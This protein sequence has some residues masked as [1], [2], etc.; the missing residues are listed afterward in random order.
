MFV[1][2]LSLVPPQEDQTKNRG[3]PSCRTPSH[4]GCFATPT[5]NR[6]RETEQTCGPRCCRPPAPAPLPP[7]RARY[8]PERQLLG[9]AVGVII[10]G[11]P[12]MSILN[13]GIQTFSGNHPK[14]RENGSGFSKRTRV[15]K[16]GKGKSTPRSI[17]PFV[18][19]PL[20]GCWALGHCLL[21]V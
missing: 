16:N 19:L 15:E 1:G 20:L 7:G 10:R 8:C 3:G 4:L 2:T 17:V 9:R 18:E 6:T 11:V 14:P 13:R 12:S 5:P 21:G